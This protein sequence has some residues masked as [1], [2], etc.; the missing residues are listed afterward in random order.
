[1]EPGL[2]NP[3][4]TGY[5]VALIKDGGLAGSDGALGLVE[6]GLDAVLVCDAERGGRWLVAVAD[7]DA[8]ADRLGG[9]GNGDPVE[10]I[11]CET[12]GEKL[13]VGAYFDAV[14]VGV[15]LEDVEGVGAA[16]AEALAL[17]N[18]EAV[19]AFMLAERFTGCGD[20]LTG[21]VGEFAAL[22]G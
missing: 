7:F 11:C 10:T 6:D 3:A 4:A 8:D 9:C 16:D 14:G 22:L 5:F 1:M 13:I 21:R 18:R 20:Q 12:R 2:E 19:D 17:S 15:D